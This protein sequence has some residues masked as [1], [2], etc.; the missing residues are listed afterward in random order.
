MSVPLRHAAA[1]A[2]REAERSMRQRHHATR[3][4]A[5]IPLLS[6]DAATTSVNEIA[7]M[8]AIPC[9]PVHAIADPSARAARLSSSAAAGAS[10]FI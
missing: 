4:S 8:F 7:F 5:Q 2:K 9:L 1:G 3:Q 10:H 6:R